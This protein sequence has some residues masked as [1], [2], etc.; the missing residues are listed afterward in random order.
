MTSLSLVAAHDVTKWTP[1]TTW[2]DAIGRCAL[3][4]ADRG[5]KN[6]DDL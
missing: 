2:A 6:R 1:P 3:L 5:P 4:V